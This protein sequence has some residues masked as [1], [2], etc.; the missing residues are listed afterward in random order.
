MHHQKPGI[1]LLSIM[2]IV[3]LLIGFKYQLIPFMALGIVWA[4][5]TSLMIKV[6][7]YSQFRVALHLLIISVVT[8]VCLHYLT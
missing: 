7:R 2:S 5:G 6:L 3:L 4:I 8:T 1:V